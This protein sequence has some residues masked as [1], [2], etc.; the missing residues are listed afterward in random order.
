[1]VRDC[2]I[3]L[4]IGVTIPQTVVIEGKGSIRLQECGHAGVVC[5]GNL[6]AVKSFLNDFRKIALRF[7]FLLL[8]GAPNW[9]L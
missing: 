4:V 2:H 1:M 3:L 7:L 5:L 6:L 8:D 9:C